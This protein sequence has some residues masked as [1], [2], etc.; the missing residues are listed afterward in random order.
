MNRRMITIDG[1]TAVATVAHATN[2]VIAIYPITPSSGMGE[3]ADALSAAGKK[4]IWGTIPDVV[5]MQSES[6]AA[7]AVH[8]VALNGHLAI[9][10]LARRERSR[11]YGDDGEAAVV[12]GAHPGAA[13]GH[14]L[15]LQRS[16]PRIGQ[17]NE[18][19]EWVSGR[20]SALGQ[21]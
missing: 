5:E 14:G 3:V 1:N 7:G 15:H 20:R 16:L 12:I 19:Q 9:G 13:G 4:N 2:E 11:I 18:R 17:R 8:G 21:A 6:G 10:V